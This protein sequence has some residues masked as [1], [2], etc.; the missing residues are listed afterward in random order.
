MSLE[1]YGFLT[2]DCPA[3]FAAVCAS[4]LL[5]ATVLDLAYGLLIIPGVWFDCANFLFVG[6]RAA[7]LRFVYGLTTV[8]RVMYLLVVFALIGVELQLLTVNESMIKEFGSCS[9]T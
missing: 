3:L 1:M 7:G 5:E 9:D 4:L 2:N 6:M 8:P